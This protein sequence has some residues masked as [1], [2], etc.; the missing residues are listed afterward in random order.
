LWRRNFLFSVLYI[1]ER[2]VA[3]KYTTSFRASLSHIHVITHTHIF[4]CI[5][6]LTSQNMTHNTTQPE[7]ASKQRKI[8]TTRTYAWYMPIYMKSDGGAKIDVIFTW[9]THAFFNS[10]YRYAAK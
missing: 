1:M 8:N 3:N 4:Y 6:T 10:M 7:T 5:I 2:M 9:S